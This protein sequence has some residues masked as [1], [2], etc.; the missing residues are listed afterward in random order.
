MIFTIYLQNRNSASVQQTS[1]ER[2]DFWFEMGFAQWFVIRI[3]T[4][5]YDSRPILPDALAALYISGEFLKQYMSNNRA[6]ITEPMEYLADFRKYQKECAMAP[7]RPGNID[8]TEEREEESL[9]RA[10]NSGILQRPVF[11]D[12][13]M[14]RESGKYI[15]SIFPECQMEFRGFGRFLGYSDLNQIIFW[16]PFILM[17]YFYLKYY[18]EGGEI[19]TILTGIS[20][21]AGLYH[22]KREITVENQ[23]D[24]ASAGIHSVR[25]KYVSA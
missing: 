8:K 14:E 4:E 25:K 16:T 20:R 1:K 12:Q 22:A 24:L 3:L 2:E 15:K 10:I 17:R 19:V 13:K 6:D 21:N 11:L 7:F 23:R 5:F 18:K 9:F